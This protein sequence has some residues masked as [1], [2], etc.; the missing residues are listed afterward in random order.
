MALIVLLFSNMSLYQLCKIPVL[1]Q[2]FREHRQIDSNLSLLDFFSMH[3]W[4]AANDNDNDQ[5]RD[6]QLPFKEFHKV[7][8][9]QLSSPV[10]PFPQKLV[11]HF[12]KTS[13]PITDEF[14]LPD[15]GISSL[16]RPPKA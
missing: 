9:E 3:Y 6:K 13:F 4:S 5:E 16:F 1:V 2:H 7:A 10:K 12:Y 14:S 8:F 11:F 15:P